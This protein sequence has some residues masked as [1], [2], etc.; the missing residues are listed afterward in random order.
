MFDVCLFLTCILSM[1]HELLKNEMLE[2]SEMY[3]QLFVFES[4]CCVDNA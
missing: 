2:N 3:E 1:F 4:V